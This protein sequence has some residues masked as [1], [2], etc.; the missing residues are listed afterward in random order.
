MNSFLVV[1]LTES[2]IVALEKDQAGNRFTTLTIG[3]SPFPCHLL[4]PPF[5]SAHRHHPP[6]IHHLSIHHPSIHPS[7]PSPSSVRSY[8][9]VNSPPVR[10]SVDS[11]PVHR[12][13]SV[14]PCMRLIQ[15][16]A[17]R[18][19]PFYPSIHHVRPSI[20]HLSTPVN[21]RRPSV[22]R[23]PVRRSPPIRPSISSSTSVRRLSVR[24][25][26]RLFVHPPAR[27]PSVV[28]LSVVTPRPSVVCPPV[29]PSIVR[30][31][32]SARQSPSSVHSSVNPS[33][34]VQSVVYPFPLPIHRR[35]RPIHQ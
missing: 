3:I 33:S 14:R 34:P 32:P 7:T 2:L 26:V 28:R 13:L 17:T 30:H 5:L 35:I 22:V 1:Q 10:P 24:P 20:R 16:L 11:H 9:S 21:R 18:H 19:R 8:P 12:R 6:S 25:S 4:P 27:P 23:H 31:R 15:S 29:R